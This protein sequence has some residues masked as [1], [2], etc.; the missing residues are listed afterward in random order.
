MIVR[1]LDDGSMIVVNQTDHAKLSGAFAAHWGN[2]AFARPEPRESAIRAAMAHDNGWLRYETAPAYDPVAKT[3]PSFFQTRTDAAQLA[4]FGW[5]I[6]WLTDIDAYA[7]AL[8]S[9]HR[10]G[11]YRG[12][13]GAITQPAGVLRDE[14]P[15]ELQ[16]FVARY[17]AGQ[18]AA[19]A[20]L[21]REAFLVNYRLLQVWDLLSLAL[22]LREPR[23]EVFAPVPRSYADGG[24]DSVELRMTPRDGTRITLDPYPFDERPLEVSLVYRRLPSD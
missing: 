17:E 14:L 22:C 7:G 15:D 10:T 4:A 1:K 12:R 3:S 8:A 19:L 18:E 13:Y 23:E 16:A 24:A 2:D 5:A 9:R 6:D 20:A 11:L 21:P